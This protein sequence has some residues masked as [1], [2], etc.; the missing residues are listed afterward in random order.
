MGSANSASSVATRI[1]SLV[2]L[3]AHQHFWRFTPADYPWMSAEMQ[4]LKRDWLPE[5]L[6]PLLEEQRIDACIAVQARASEAETDFLL[7]L[8]SQYPWIAAVVGWIDLRAD[9]IEQRLARWL[10]APA[11]AGFRHQIQDEA[12][13]AAYA[14]DARVRRGM[15]LIQREQLAYDVLVFSHQIDAVTSLCRD[16]DQY[17]LVLDH[18]GKPRIHAHDHERW[19][20][21]V[22]PLA[23]MPHV[24]CK[25]SGLVTE[26][27]DAA[28]EVHLD[29]LRR[30]LDTALE[31]F[32]PQRLMFGSDWPVCL[33]ATSYARAA[34]IVESWSA[35]LTR[36]EREWLW[37]RSAQ[38]AYSLA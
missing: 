29:E 26:A 13:V 14:D 36:D 35:K 30:H 21:A 32:G 3:D 16:C 28:G 19:R 1:E 5:D 7:M 23:A 22:A 18:L 33:L 4:V 9:D 38:R 10:E 24:M 15:R 8:A 37:Y 17:W 27:M 20:R 31:L 12:D 25:I 11:L 2:R 6:R 34:A